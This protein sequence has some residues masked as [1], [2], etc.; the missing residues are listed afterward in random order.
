MKIECCLHSVARGTDV[1]GIYHDEG[2]RGIGSRK[3]IYPAVQFDKN[4]RNLLVAIFVFASDYP[5]QKKGSGNSPATIV[6]C[7]YDHRRHYF[8]VAAPI[9]FWTRTT[10]NMKPKRVCEVWERTAGSGTA[11]RTLHT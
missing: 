10:A 11:R 6:P 5:G 9:P 8:V 2:S 7:Y 4:G 3:R 1:P